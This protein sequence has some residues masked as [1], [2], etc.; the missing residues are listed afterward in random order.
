M[1]HPEEWEQ[2]S[3]DLCNLFGFKKNTHPLIFLSNG[4]FIGSNED[5]F[6]WV[7]KNFNLSIEQNF[8]FD[9][10]LIKKLTQENIAF[11]NKEY[12]T[13]INGLKIKEKIEQKVLQLDFEEGDEGSY[14]FNRYNTLESDYEIDF[15][16]GMKIF[17][18]IHDKFLPLPGEYVDYGDPVVEGKV[19]IEIPKK[20]GESGIQENSMENQEEENENEE[21]EDSQEE[22]K[23]SIII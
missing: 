20:S 18:K 5:F 4:N 11:V 14:Y 16:N 17:Y 21:Y 23:K 22:N 7:E 15:M 3:E 12:E 10:N 13:R 19:E 2:Y 9:V 1:K 6:K 8:N